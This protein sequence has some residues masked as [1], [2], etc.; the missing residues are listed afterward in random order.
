MSK[1]AAKR[2]EKRKPQM[3]I[4]MLMEWLSEYPQDKEILFETE[5][6][7]LF[8]IFTMSHNPSEPIKCHV[9]AI[10]TELDKEATLRMCDEIQKEKA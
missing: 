3:K 4:S 8:G 1:K 5:D 7:K 10:L 9:T 2:L 6:G